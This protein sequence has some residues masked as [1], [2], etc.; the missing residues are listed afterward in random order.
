M[1]FSS[2][3]TRLN[4]MYSKVVFEVLHEIQNTL[5]KLITLL[6]TEYLLYYTKIELRCCSYI[7]R[8][9]IRMML[10]LKK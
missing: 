10:K 4:G 8:L 3:F 2:K 6:H 9:F 7:F 1:R 5:H